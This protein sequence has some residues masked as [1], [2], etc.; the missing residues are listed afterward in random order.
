MAYY[1]KISLLILNEDKIKFLVC[2]KAPEN[3]MCDYIM[4]GGK[5]KEKNDIDCLKNEIKEE[6]SCD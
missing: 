5:L 3:V 1:N 6:L 4:P 2:E